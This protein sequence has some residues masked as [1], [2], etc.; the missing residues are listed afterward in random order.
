M[1]SEVEDTLATLTT[2]LKELET[3][4]GQLTDTADAA[5]PPS[6]AGPGGTSSGTQNIRV[7]VPREKRFGKYAGTR[8][9]RV[10]E[11]WISDA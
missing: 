5:P 3:Q 11:D 2:R 4:L 8:D 9:D 7:S 10:L 1:P 6:T